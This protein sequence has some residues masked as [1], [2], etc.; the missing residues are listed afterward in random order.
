MPSD[1]SRRLCPISSAAPWPMPGLQNHRPR[2]A[3]DRP[4]TDTLPKLLLRGVRPEISHQLGVQGGSPKGGEGM[5]CEKT[6]RC[7]AGEETRRK[8][9]WAGARV[10]LSSQEKTI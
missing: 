10:I 9:S 4:Y 2:D 3:M 1:E 5:P 6:L 8:S 7:G